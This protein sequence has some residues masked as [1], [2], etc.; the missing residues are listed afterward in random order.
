MRVSTEMQSILDELNRVERKAMSRLSTLSVNNLGVGLIELYYKRDNLH[1]RELI[2]EFLSRA[3]VVWLRK[4]LTKD[5]SPIASSV[6]RFATL[7]DYVG[8]LAA[9]DLEVD[10]ASNA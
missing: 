5:T 8:L 2:R 3:G 7:K 9:N 10:L 4:L 1:T 6:T